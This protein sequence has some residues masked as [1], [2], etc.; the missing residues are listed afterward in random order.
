MDQFYDKD[1]VK[2]LKKCKRIKTELSCL[3]IQALL[4]KFLQWILDLFSS[5]SI[6]G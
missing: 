5:F 4:I 6:Y 3:I 2:F 1:E